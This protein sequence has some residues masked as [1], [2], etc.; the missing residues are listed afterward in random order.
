M[1]SSAGVKLPVFSRGAPGV[2]LEDAREILTRVEAGTL[3]DISDG[4]LMISEHLFG[5]IDTDA[6]EQGDGA[7]TG[8]VSG[9]FG[10]ACA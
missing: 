6:V 3:G 9:Q 4:P 2:G 10:K 5:A 1:H 8:E 7:F